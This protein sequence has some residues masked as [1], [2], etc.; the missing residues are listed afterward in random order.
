LS[1]EKESER[2]RE[3]TDMKIQYG[4]YTYSSYLGS[5]TVDNFIT[6]LSPGS[7]RA[8]TVSPLTPLSDH[9]KITAYLH[10]STLKQEGLKPN[11]LQ[12]I[13]K[14]YRWKESSVETYQNTIKQNL[15]VQQRRDQHGS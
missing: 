15:S 11:K 8:F 10:R 5:S 6:D 9:S 12:T 3:D 1:K 2:E 4:R 14:C 13:N 7:L